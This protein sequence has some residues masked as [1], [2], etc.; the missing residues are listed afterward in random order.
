MATR[1][2]S[3]PSFAVPARGPGEIAL[4]F[5][6]S[7]ATTIN[8]Q[9]EAG[10]MKRYCVTLTH[11]RGDVLPKSECVTASSMDAAVAMVFK[12]I[13][14]DEQWEWREKSVSGHPI[15]PQR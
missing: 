1:R 13:P 7:N 14:A 2:I 4:R 5:H 11:V 6:P 10:Q 9:L 8:C 15:N 12:A 3:A